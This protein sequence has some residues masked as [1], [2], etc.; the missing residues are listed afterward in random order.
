MVETRDP[1]RHGIAGMA[2]N[3][4]RCRR[5][6]QSF[7]HSQQSPGTSDLRRRCAGRPAQPNKRDPLRILQRTERVPL[8]SRHRP[9][10]HRSTTI[11]AYSNPGDPLVV[12]RQCESEDGTT[13]LMCFCPQASSMGI[14]DRATYREADPNSTALRSVEGFKNPL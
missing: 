7:G 5:V 13:W 9:P 11:M 8:L 12:S 1:A 3:K 6:T 4:L 14:N 2:A 10:P